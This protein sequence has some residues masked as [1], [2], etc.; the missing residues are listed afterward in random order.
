MDFTGEMHRA[1]SVHGIP[2][3]RIRGT[4]KLCLKPYIHQGLFRGKT[5]HIFR[6]L[7]GCPAWRAPQ[8]INRKNY[9]VFFLSGKLGRAEEFSILPQAYLPGKPAS[10][11]WSVSPFDSKFFPR[12]HNWY[13]F[14][15]TYYGKVMGQVRMF[16][17]IQDKIRIETG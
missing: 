7:P 3:G 17:K 12:G 5:N 13:L 16:Q 1:F 10:G 11:G 4:E 15:S 2:G 9:S 8:D 6:R 14:I